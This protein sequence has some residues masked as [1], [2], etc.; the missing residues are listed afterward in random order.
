[1]KA[2]AKKR[3]GRIFL[4][5]L[6]VLVVVVLLAIGGLAIYIRASYETEI[7]ASLFGLEIVDATTR[8]YYCEDRKSVV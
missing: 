5:I 8:F 6:L 7:D 1:M 2:K 4:R 3:S